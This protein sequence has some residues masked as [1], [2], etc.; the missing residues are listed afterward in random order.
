LKLGENN[1]VVKPSIA[2]IDVIT[3]P[4]STVGAKVGIMS[5]AEG[6]TGL[7]DGVDEGVPV[8]LSAQLQMHAL[9]CLIW[10]SIF[11]WSGF[12]FPQMVLQSHSESEL[13][14]LLGNELF[15]DEP[16]GVFEGEEV[17]IFGMSVIVAVIATEVC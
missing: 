9:R 11:C 14:A 5:D 12:K 3:Y 8:G 4:S 1:V 6:V 16:L 17:K 15:V 10:L 13:G 7:S 2:M